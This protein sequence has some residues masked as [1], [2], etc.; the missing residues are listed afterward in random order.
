MLG[1]LSIA[2]VSFLFGVVGALPTHLL[3]PLAN[4]Q[5]AATFFG[6]GIVIALTSAAYLGGLPSAV[7]LIQSYGSWAFIVGALVVLKS[8]SGAT[9]PTLQADRPLA[10]PSA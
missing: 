5:L 10:R 3:R 4:S 6:A 7:A 8:R 2:A 1:P 9:Q